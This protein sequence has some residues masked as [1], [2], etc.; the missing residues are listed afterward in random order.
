MEK[1]SV[2]VH[3]K[4]SLVLWVVDGEMGAGSLLATAP[5]PLAA[6]S[7]R[8]VN[9]NARV[10][11]IY[12]NAVV[13][14]T[15]GCSEHSQIDRCNMFRVLTCL[16]EVGTKAWLSQVSAV[17]HEGQELKKHSRKS[18]QS[19]TRISYCENTAASRSTGLSSGGSVD[20]SD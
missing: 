16:A 4:Q 2:V 8:L 18:R 20:G 11:R 13:W 1:C 12:F 5:P 14:Q 3:G 19:L 17:R 9:I 15:G 7:I 6:A 10:A